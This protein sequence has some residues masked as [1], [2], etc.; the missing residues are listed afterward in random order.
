MTPEQRQKRNTEMVQAATNGAS[1]SEIAAQVGL[2]LTWVGRVIRANGGPAPAHRK[3][4]KRDIDQDRYREAYEGGKSVRA[5]AD[6]AGVS[7]SAMYRRLVKAGVTFR[8]RG[9]PP[10]TT[11]R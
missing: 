1:Y 2:S 4:F 7:Y 8:P 9:G 11:A 6:H 3:G 5:L 10:Q